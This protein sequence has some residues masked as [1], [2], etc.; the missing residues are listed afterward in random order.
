MK[1][2]SPIGKGTKKET[3]RKSKGHEQKTQTKWES[4]WKSW[5]FSRNKK[6]KGP[7]SRIPF[8]IKT[9]TKKSPRP[10]THQHLTRYTIYGIGAWELPASLS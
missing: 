10:P 9:R 3:K 7:R 1:T 5:G 4:S 8:W 2:G 6:T